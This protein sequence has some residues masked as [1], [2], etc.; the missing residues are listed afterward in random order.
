MAFP[1]RQTGA[2]ASFERVRRGAQEMGAGGCERR[3][4]A[5]F[6]RR[7]QDVGDRPL[8]ERRDDGEGD[9]LRVGSRWRQDAI[10]IRIFAIGQDAGA[11]IVEPGGFGSLQTR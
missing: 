7:D 3:A 9:Q 5:R 8:P 4:A 10:G 6:L 11:D 1:A 2:L